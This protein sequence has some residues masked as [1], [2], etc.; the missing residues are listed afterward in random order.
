M[1]PRR[2]LPSGIL[3]R[4]LPLA[5]FAAAPAFAQSV[6]DHGT[7]TIHETA[8][9]AILPYWGLSIRGEWPTQCPPT[10]QNVALDGS[11]LRIDAR[12]VLDLCE[13]QSTPFAIEVNP[14]LAMQRA[15][16]PAGVYHASFYAADGAQ[17]R[18]YGLGVR[19]L[20]LRQAQDLAAQAELDLGEEAAFFPSDEALARWREA[21][22]EQHAEI[23]Y[24]A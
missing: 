16:L 22:H 19:L 4:L 9:R 23:V 8:A 6:A 14:A 1:F 15:T 24:G 18:T 3:E 2:F 17:A 11:D 5:L 10:L 21:A 7:V 13:R 12:S 20:V